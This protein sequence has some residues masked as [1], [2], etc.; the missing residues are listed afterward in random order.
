MV[1]EDSQLQQPD[2]HNLKLLWADFMAAI[3]DGRKGVASIE[4]AHRSSVLPLLGMISA[5]VGR[6]IEWDGAT[7][8]IIGDPA[9]SR[10]MRRPYRGPWTYPEV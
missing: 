4:I 2:G 9:A 5:R 3:D 6:S 10:L 8:Q 1:H 7:E